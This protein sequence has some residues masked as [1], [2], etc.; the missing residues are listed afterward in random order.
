MR[1]MLNRHIDIENRT[2]IVTLEANNETVIQIRLQMAWDGGLIWILLTSVIFRP[3][4]GWRVT[5]INTNTTF[6]GMMGSDRVS[7]QL[8]KCPLHERGKVES[9]MITEKN[10]ITVGIWLPAT[11]GIQMVNMCLIAKWSINWMVSRIGDKKSGY[12][13]VI[14]YLWTNNRHLLTI[15]PFSKWTFCPLFRSPFGYLIKSQVTGCFH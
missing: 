7:V 4:T 1:N 8:Y 5:T 10:Y 11:S 6:F 2:W 3:M 12:W 14:R 13:M 9:Q 15:R